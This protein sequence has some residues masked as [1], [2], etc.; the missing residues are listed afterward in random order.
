MIHADSACTCTPASSTR[1]K[2]WRTRHDRHSWPSRRNSACS[3]SRNRG[4]L[5]PR[6]AQTRAGLLHVTQIIRQATKS[7]GGHVNYQRLL[8]I[9]YL[10]ERTK[11]GRVEMGK[12]QVGNVGGCNL[13]LP[14]GIPASV[15][16]DNIARTTPTLST[17]VFEMSSCTQP[18][19][20]R[21]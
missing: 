21:R 12:V 9:R 14:T 15:H 1:S 19:P 8:S 5:C 10:E 6:H 20:I 13:Q 7:R 2:L 17:P 11:D 16:E 3:S 4:A 18:H